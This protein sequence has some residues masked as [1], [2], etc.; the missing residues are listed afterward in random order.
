VCGGCSDL[1]SPVGPNG[2]YVCEGDAACASGELCTLGRCLPS[3]NI[4]CRF[5]FRCAE[6]EQCVLSGFSDE[7]RGNAETRSFCQASP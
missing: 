4:A 6:N 3:A 1:C 5:M 7:G 2:D